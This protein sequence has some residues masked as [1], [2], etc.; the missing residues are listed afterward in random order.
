MPIFP[1]CMAIFSGAPFCLL[2]SFERVLGVKGVTNGNG[3]LTGKLHHRKV[4][5]RSQTVPEFLPFFWMFRDDFFERGKGGALNFKPLRMT[6][7]CVPR[8]LWGLPYMSQVCVCAHCG[9][10]RAEGGGQQRKK[11]G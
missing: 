10:E 7:P 4:P 2:I 3:K 6:S 1:G 8:L 5:T 11:D 9:N